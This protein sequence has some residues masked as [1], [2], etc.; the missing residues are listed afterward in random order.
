MNKPFLWRVIFSDGTYQMILSRSYADVCLTATELCPG[1]A[2][3]ER[4]GEW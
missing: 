4:E 3:I 2:R 1:F